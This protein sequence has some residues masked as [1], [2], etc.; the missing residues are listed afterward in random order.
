MIHETI[1]QGKWYED[2]TM[3]LTFGDTRGY[4]SIEYEEI[5]HILGVIIVKQ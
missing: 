1:L 3:L 4:P 2:G 5:E